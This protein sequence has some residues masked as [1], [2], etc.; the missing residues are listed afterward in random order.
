MRRPA[1]NHAQELAVLRISLAPAGHRTRSARKTTSKREGR[2]VRGVVSVCDCEMSMHRHS[3]SKVGARRK[4]KT[5]GNNDLQ[6]PQRVP[7]GVHR[8]QAYLC[9]L[10]QFGLTLIQ[11]IAMRPEG[12]GPCCYGN[13]GRWRICS[14]GDVEGE[15]ERTQSY[16]PGNALSSANGKAALA[17]EM[18]MPRPPQSNRGF[19]LYGCQKTVLELDVELVWIVARCRPMGGRRLTKMRLGPRARMAQHQVHYSEKCP[20]GFRAAHRAP[21]P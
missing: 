4:E 10:I 9:A 1:R 19:R 15:D 14:R 6:R 3:Y 20:F 5:E 16:G 21:V 2:Q 13:G 7:P 18:P 8:G 17:I 11:K 12:S